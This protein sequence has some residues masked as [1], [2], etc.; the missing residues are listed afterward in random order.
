MHPHHKFD[1]GIKSPA[2]CPVLLNTIFFVNENV[3]Q[4]L[5]AQF[6]FKHYKETESKKKNTTINNKLAVLQKCS[7]PKKEVFEPEEICISQEISDKA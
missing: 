6:Y 2:C 7:M 4:L 3:T 5:D 1:I